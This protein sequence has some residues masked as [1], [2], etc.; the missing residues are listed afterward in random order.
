MKLA[1]LGMV[2][3]LT[4][5]YGFIPYLRIQRTANALAGASGVWMF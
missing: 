5:I 3:A 4:W 1:I 2:A